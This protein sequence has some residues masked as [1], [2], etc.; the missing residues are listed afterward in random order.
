[1]SNPWPAHPAA[2]Q[3]LRAALCLTEVT[4]QLLHPGK[5]T[6]EVR[7]TF[8]RVQVHLLQRDLSL[9][10]GLRVLPQLPVLSPNQAKNATGTAT[11]TS[12]KQTTM[13]LQSA[14]KY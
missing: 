7:L 1:M 12:S 6:V 8:V 11:C 14:S 3:A 4:H 2:E 10:V 5:L 9:Q 13:Q